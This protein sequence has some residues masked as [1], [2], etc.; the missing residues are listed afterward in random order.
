MSKSLFYKAICL[1][2]YE[3]HDNI[4]YVSISIYRRLWSTVVNQSAGW[5]SC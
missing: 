2:I 1:M 5:A 3:V 4:S